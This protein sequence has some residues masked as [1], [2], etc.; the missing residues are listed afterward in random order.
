MLTQLLDK[1][2]DMSIGDSKGDSQDATTLMHAVCYSSSV[3]AHQLI[4]HPSCSREILNAKTSS[5][6]LSALHIAIQQNRLDVIKALVRKGAKADITQEH[7]GYITTVQEQ[8]KLCIDDKALRKEVIDF[9][10]AE[11]IKQKPWRRRR[12]ATALFVGVGAEEKREREAPWP[13][14][15]YKGDKNPLTD[16]KRGVEL[17][18]SM[19]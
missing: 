4:D 13:F 9:L 14:Q 8:A 2:A 7:R 11:T 10:K 12:F 19:M 6:G 3:I 5:F 1:R 15:Q 17:G 18:C 16:K